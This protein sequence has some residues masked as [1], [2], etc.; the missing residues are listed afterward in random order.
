MLR[1]D[2]K[3]KYN[4]SQMVIG[5]L[6][7][8]IAVAIGYCFVLSGQLHTAN[9]NVMMLKAQVET[10]RT[11]KEELAAENELLQE[12]VLV[13]SDT[14][15]DKMQQEE[16]REELDAR[17]AQTYIPKGFPVKGAASFSE[18]E[19][20]L[21]GN[22]IVVFSV[23]KGTSVVPTAKGTVSSIA[24]SEVAGYIVMID[25]GNGYFSVYR[26]GTEPKVRE[27]DEVTVAT[28]I[29]AIAEGFEELG[30]Q[31]IQNEVYIN[32]LD[33]METYG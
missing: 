30:Y 14:V 15:N 26:N 5:V 16:K 21:D 23:P 13:L 29:F 1:E 17:L 28:E 25:H 24:G 12:K 31:V 18:N 11:E 19:T 20:E 6:I 10:L 7:V 32:P 4:S 9:N 3:A 27:G 22:P 2:K 8:L 33:L